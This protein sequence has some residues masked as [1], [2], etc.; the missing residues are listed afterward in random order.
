MVKGLKWGSC[1]SDYLILEIEHRH[2]LNESP[3]VAGSDRTDGLMFYGRSDK[4][5]AVVSDHHRKYSK[6]LQIKIALF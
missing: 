4:K 1:F 3:A 5:M 6:C 2:P